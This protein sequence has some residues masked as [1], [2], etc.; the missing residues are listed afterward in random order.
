MKIKVAILDENVSYLNRL[1]AA[2]ASRFAEKLEVY[3]FSNQES[4]LT[5]LQNNRID[6]FLSSDRFDIDYNRLP[7]RCGFSYLVDSA[8]IES[9]KEK[10]TICRFQKVEMIY[11]EIL[12][13]FSDIS[14]DTI[15]FE[16]G[17][18][19]AIV[20]F[21]STC[22]G[23]G[24]STVAAAFAKRQAMFGKKVLYLNLEQFGSAESFFD[25]EGQFGLSDVIFAVKS[26]KSSLALKMESYIKTDPSGVYFYSAAK[27]PLDIIEI[28]SEDIDSLV[29]AM[30]AIGSFDIIVVDADF[31]ISADAIELIKQSTATV[32]VSTGTDIANTK[33]LRAISALETYEQQNDV[34]VLGKILL[35]YN[36]FSSEVCKMLSDSP[37]RV[38]GGISR[39]E[40]ASERRV[41]E[42]VM[43]NNVLDRIFG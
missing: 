37:I 33:F 40:N 11:K 21:M 35:L 18:G 34:S 31:S 25:G 28:G 43:Q 2:F 29:A 7:K 14:P 12:G 10:P 24:S 13:I 5:S 36:R 3:S 42:Q 6:V 27:N 39:I 32:F 15:K 30:R 19:G 9:F 8:G 38:C 26:K 41:V 17:D 22:G 20:S 4:A 1:A 16:T 23:A